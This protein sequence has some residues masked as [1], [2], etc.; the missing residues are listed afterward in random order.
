MTTLTVAFPISGSR[1][2]VGYAN[3]TGIAV[4]R[5][6]SSPSNMLLR[7]QLRHHVSG[8]RKG[9]GDQRQ[10]G[11]GLMMLRMNDAA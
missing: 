8:S 1:K 7:P 6:S 10:A 9:Y 4:L 3:L 2:D 11:A 5:M